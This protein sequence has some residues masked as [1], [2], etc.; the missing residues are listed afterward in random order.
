VLLKQLSRWV[1]SPQK[2]QENRMRPSIY[3][4]VRVVG[5]E[6]SDGDEDVRREL[7]AHA[8]REGFALDQIFKDRVQS[9]EPAFSSMLDALKTGEVKDV[10]VP[11]LWHFARLP[12]LQ[13]AM[14]QHVELETGA[15]I[16]VVNGPR[17][18]DDS[19]WM[20]DAVSRLRWPSS[21]PV[22]PGS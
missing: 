1:G 7:A 5:E 4:Y 21:A 9:S 13:D 18:R 6:G 2:D 8:E 14:R 20:R 16:W 19:L 3:G 12:G 22:D 15:R 10:I 17:Y 11:S